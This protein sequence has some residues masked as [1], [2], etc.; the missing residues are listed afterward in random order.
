LQLS[1]SVRRHLRMSV[2]IELPPEPR[3]ADVEAGLVRVRRLRRTYLIAS[4][5]FLPVIVGIG[6]LATILFPSSRRLQA[7]IGLAAALGYMRWANRVEG[8][9]IATRCPRC[10]GPFH[11]PSPWGLGPGLPLHV[12]PRRCQTCG[13]HLNVRNMSGHDV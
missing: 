10:G 8:R 4:L 2:T 11:G 12:Y 7:V 5:A 6:F 9:V 13:L 3:P 1:L